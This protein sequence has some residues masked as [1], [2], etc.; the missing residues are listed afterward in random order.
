MYLEKNQSKERLQTEANTQSF[1]SLVLKNKLNGVEFYWSQ[2]AGF[3]SLATHQPL[4]GAAG[5]STPPQSKSM[6]DT[7]GKLY[8]FRPRSSNQGN[9]QTRWYE[10]KTYLARDWIVIEQCIHK[11]KTLSTVCTYFQTRKWSIPDELKVP[12]VLMCVSKGFDYWSW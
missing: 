9:L 4:N 7:A 2:E 6:L 12:L 11:S 3:V 5:Y 1:L 10:E 8:H